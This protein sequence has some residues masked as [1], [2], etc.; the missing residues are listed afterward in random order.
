MPTFSAVKFAP[1]PPDTTFRPIPTVEENPPEYGFH[2]RLPPSAQNQEAFDNCEF[3]SQAYGDGVSYSR[4]HILLRYELLFQHETGHLKSQY[5]IVPWMLMP[6]K[7]DSPTTVNLSVSPLS[8]YDGAIAKTA[9]SELKKKIG[10]STRVI[11]LVSPTDPTIQVFWGK[12]GSKT[13]KDESDLKD[14][15]PVR[16]V[17]PKGVYQGIKMI[18]IKTGSTIL[19]KARLS[20]SDILAQPIC[21]MKINALSAN[22]K[23]KAKLLNPIDVPKS[24]EN[25]TRL[26][27][28]ASSVFKTYG[29]SLET[30]EDAEFLDGENN[31]LVSTQ[32]E[33][34]FDADLNPDDKLGFDSR[35]LHVD[36]KV[37]ELLS[38]ITKFRHTVNGTSKVEEFH[39][40]Y[41]AVLLPFHFK[42]S[43]AGYTSLPPSTDNGVLD[44]CLH[45]FIFPAGK[46]WEEYY[47]TRK[48]TYWPNMNESDI[49]INPV[50]NPYGSATLIH[51]FLHALLLRHTFLNDRETIDSL[52]NNYRNYLKSIG[53]TE[54]GT[55]EPDETIPVLFD[56]MREMDLKKAVVDE[57]LIKLHGSKIEDVS[58]PLVMGLFTLAKLNNPVIF[59]QFA[60]RNIMDYFK[61][62]IDPKGTLGFDDKLRVDLNWSGTEKKV[63]FKYQ[64]ELARATVAF[65][66]SY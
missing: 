29:I 34:E 53:L 15:T 39:R 40:L 48:K 65:L 43:H 46:Y 32:M 16:I 55:V 63:L 50:A 5:Y 62:E 66:A 44:A 22:N 26:D 31:V 8:I 27:L 6:S 7:L 47:E 33:F 42:S 64:W 51:E 17:I 9:K 38:K 23:Y 45:S 4:N 37:M 25:G 57:Y 11:E 52:L 36:K 1:Y 24:F 58:A 49:T 14:E 3:Y 10:S 59:N 2:F 28:A 18:E 19:G 54:F 13:T 60:T 20:F 30:I 12:S 56:L 61:S 35:A 41:L 21:F